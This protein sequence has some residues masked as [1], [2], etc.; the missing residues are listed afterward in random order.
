MPI[1]ATGADSDRAPTDEAR[2]RETQRFIDDPKANAYIQQPM[3]SPW[4]IE[5]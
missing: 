3:R 2:H 4:K 1:T 5:V